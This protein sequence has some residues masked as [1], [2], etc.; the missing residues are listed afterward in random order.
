M[1]HETSID[2][3]LTQRENLCVAYRVCGVPKEER[4]DRTEKLLDHVE[5][6]STTLDAV[7]AADVLLIVVD[8]TDGPERIREKVEVTREPFDELR[9]ELV[10]VLNKIDLVDDVA[11]RQRTVQELAARVLL[12]SA[13][14]GTGIEQA[15]SRVEDI[16]DQGAE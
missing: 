9:G 10:V 3:E 4:A 1:A 11:E 8:V 13:L 16:R 7:A 15:R 5:S 14:E 2:F 12:V 6:F